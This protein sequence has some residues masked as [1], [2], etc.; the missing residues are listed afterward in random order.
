MKHANPAYR[1]FDVRKLAT[2]RSHIAIDAGVN[3]QGQELPGGLS[4]KSLWKI[5]KGATDDFFEHF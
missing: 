3:L 4:K 1:L 2:K 5:L